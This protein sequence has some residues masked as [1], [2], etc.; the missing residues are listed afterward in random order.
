MP[1]TLERR[2]LVLAAVGAVAVWLA[3]DRLRWLPADPVHAAK[4]HAVQIMQ[5]GIVVLRAERT[6]RGLT[7]DGAVDPN[8]TG[9]IGSAYTDLTT[10]LGVLPAK[11]TSTNP[12]MAGLV[13][14]LLVQAG[15]GRGDAI[16]VAFSGSFPALNLAVLAAAR[17]MELRPV[18]ISSVGA[19]SYGANEPGWTWPDMERVLAE[20]GIIRHRSTRI[21]L[22]GIVDE[23]GGLDGTGFELGG[24]AVRR[25]G[26]PLLDEGGRATLEHDVARRM[27]LFRD[28]CGGTP[29]AFVNVGGALTSLGGSERQVFPAGLIRQLE[30]PPEPRRG[31]IARMIADGVPVV[32]L[33]DVR[34]LASRYGLPFDPVP[35][36]TGPV[37][38]VIRPRRLGQALAAGGLGV[39]LIVLVAAERRSRKMRGEALARP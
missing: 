24:A 21:A 9:L 14:E 33:L 18:I 31:V 5:E 22:G 10:T 16:A 7:W 12:N 26:V 2:A 1:T 34:K 6:R 4:L 39:L 19:S 32:H 37:G 8:R 23:Q 3:V 15:T 36:P 20:R 38:A 30:L 27:E 25:S 29:K 13:V 35:L 28:G 11:R 17:A